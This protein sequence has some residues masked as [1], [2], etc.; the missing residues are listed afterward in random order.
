MSE[1]PVVEETTPED[2][3]A[4]IEAAVGAVV[5]ESPE[6]VEPKPVVEQQLHG[7]ADY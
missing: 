6:V 4:I 2:A 1:Q 3:A 7:N 5:D